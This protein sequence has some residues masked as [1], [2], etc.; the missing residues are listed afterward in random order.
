[1][2]VD[3]NY[4]THLRYNSRVKSKVIFKKHIY[5]YKKMNCIYPYLDIV[6]VIYAL[7]W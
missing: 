1:M 5:L 4:L 2:T 6:F 3:F 7:F